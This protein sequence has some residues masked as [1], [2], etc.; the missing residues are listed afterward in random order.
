MAR[1]VR[2]DS[3]EIMPDGRLQ[4]KITEGVPPLPK[5]WGGVVVHYVSKEAMVSEIQQL[6]AVFDTTSLR[7]LALSTWYK[8]DPQ[9]ATVSYAAGKVA[10]VDLLGTTTAISVK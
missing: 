8:V 4:V 1:T 10:T 7:N 2:I 9:L 3:V 6:D 5:E